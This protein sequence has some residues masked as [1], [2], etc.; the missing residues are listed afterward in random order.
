MRARV[1]TAQRARPR[2][3]CRGRRRSYH[4][5][6]SLLAALSSLLTAARLWAP[7]RAFAGCRRLH[8]RATR[9]A[10]VCVLSLPLPAG[11]RAR[12]RRI[13]DAQRREW[14][15]DGESRAGTGEVSPS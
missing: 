15:G 11:A 9:W 10:A 13:I 12:V 4:L 1:H 7:C 3:A 5:S 14:A 6:L 2:C 8:G